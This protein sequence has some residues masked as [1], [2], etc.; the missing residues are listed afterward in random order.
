MNA[1]AL[2]I[3]NANYTQEKDRLINAVNDADDIEIGRAHV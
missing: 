1:L 2:V 3:G